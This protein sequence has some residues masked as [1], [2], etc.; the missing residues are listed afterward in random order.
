MYQA[1]NKCSNKSNKF[2]RNPFHKINNQHI[3]CVNIK[4][5]TEKKNVNTSVKEYKSNVS[6]KH[7]QVRLQ[8]TTQFN[9]VLFINTMLN[10]LHCWKNK[11]IWNNKSNI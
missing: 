5:T 8:M 6:N 2:K 11:L 10:V 4:T 1:D 9:T 7:L 3:R